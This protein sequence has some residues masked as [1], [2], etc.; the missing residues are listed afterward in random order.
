[1]KAEW[2]RKR[3]EVSIPL[4]YVPGELAEVDFFEVQLDVDGKRRKAWMFVMRL[5][6]SGRDFAWLYAHQD[7]ALLGVPWRRP[8]RCTDVAFRMRYSEISHND[9]MSSPSPWKSLC[10]QARTRRST[11]G[12]LRLG[13]THGTRGRT[14]ARNAMIHREFV[15]R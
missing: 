14:T 13:L 15:G 4:H 9:I 10:A 11:S 2:K 7:Q 5:M 12:M 6:Y 3:R 8:R 1:M